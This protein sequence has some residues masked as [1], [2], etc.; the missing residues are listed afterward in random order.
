MLFEILNWCVDLLFRKFSMQNI[1]I[2]MVTYNRPLTLKKVIGSYLIQKNIKELIVIDDGSTKSY[3]DFISYC[4][5]ECSL[6]SIEFKYQKNTSN[7][8]AAYSRKKGLEFVTGKYVLWGEDDL[9]LDDTYIEKLMPYVNSKNAAFGSIYYEM[10]TDLPEQIKQSL[11]KAQNER[12]GELMDWRTLEGYYRYK[13]D[14]I[15]DVIYGHAVYVAPY[16]MFNGIDIYT[17]YMVNGFREET[18]IQLQLRKKGLSFL[19]VSDAECYHLKNRIGDENKGGQHKNSRVKQEIYY[20]K[21]NNLFL[22]RNYEVI[23]N[24]KSDIYSKNGLKLRYIYKRFCFNLSL[25]VNKIT[26]GKE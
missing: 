2:I 12:V 13:L 25:V 26:R 19:Y 9:F 23:R 6:K 7:R 4:T 11:I 22:D 17:G 14:K 20:I 5:K 10:D 3:D 21:N 1:S 16:S 24:Y 18:D 15:E 8:G